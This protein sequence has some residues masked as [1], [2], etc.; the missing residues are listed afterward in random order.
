MSRLA[1]APPIIILTAL[2][3]ELSPILSR[4]EQIERVGSGR[5]YRGLLGGLPAV[6]A[7]TGDGRARAERAAMALCQEF[8]PAALYGAGIAGALSS[9]L[10][11]FDI[12]VARQV[13]DASGAAPDPDPELLS[14][15]RCLGDPAAVILV[16][17]DRPIVDPGQ[18]AS[19]AAALAPEEPAAADM[20]S[21]GWARAAAR[22]GVPYAIVRAV[23]DTSSEPLPEYLGRSVGP[24]GGIRRGR[25][26]VFA[27]AHPATV[28]ALY[29]MRRRLGRGAEKLAVFVE[30]LV[31]EAA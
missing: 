20:E 12:V 21:S 14:R 28:P 22:A 13:C 8:R 31:S 19:L 1:S 24:E 5:V 26:V 15:A 7:V 27:L 11:L 23:A 9:S 17:V 16:T 3:E 25:V 6:L 2:P 4:A 18:K 10:R 30:R 29:R